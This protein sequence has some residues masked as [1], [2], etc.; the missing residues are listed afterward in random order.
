MMKRYGIDARAKKR[1]NDTYIE[2]T[3]VIPKNS[4][5]EE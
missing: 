5:E 4:G 3:I 1:E 2:Y